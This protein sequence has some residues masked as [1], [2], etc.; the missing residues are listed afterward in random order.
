MTDVAVTSVLPVSRLTMTIGFVPVLLSIDAT[1][2]LLT[3]HVTT[4]DAL[5]GPFT[6]ARYDRAWPYVVSVSAASMVTLYTVSSTTT[7]ATALT[8]SDTASTSA[9]PGFTGINRAVLPLGT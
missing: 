1:V 7:F 5:A 4:R 3:D 9:V 6:V 8:S 2:G